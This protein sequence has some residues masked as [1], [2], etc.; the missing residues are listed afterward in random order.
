MKYPK[1]TPKIEDHPLLTGAMIES[2][3]KVMNIV[4]WFKLEGKKLLKEFDKNN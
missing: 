3:V 2:Q 1:Y 4:L